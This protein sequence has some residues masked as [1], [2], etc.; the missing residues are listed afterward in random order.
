MRVLAVGG[1]AREHAIVAALA[2]SGADVFACLK[3][4]NPGI[5]KAAKAHILVDESDT[6]KIVE[7][8]KTRDVEL[9]VVGPEAP[10]EV[11]LVDALRSAGVPTA[12]PSKAAAQ[13]ETSKSF[14]RKLLSEHKVKGSIQ[15]AIVDNTRDLKLALDRMGMNV[16]VKPT[17][18]TGG[19]GVKVVGEH[20]MTK[21]DVIA[22]ADEIFTK[23]IGGSSQIVLEEK[24]VGEELTIQAFCDGRRVVPMPAVQDHKR[25]YEGD[26]GPNTGG[27]GSYS[28]N[29]GLLPFLTRKEYDSAV[30]IME[31]VVNALR[32][33]GAEYHGALYGQFMLT[34]DGPKVIE[35][36]ARFGDPEAMNVLSLLS[37]DFTQICFKMA[38]GGISRSHAEFQKKASVCKYVVPEGYG[39]KSLAG[40][41]IKVDENAIANEGALLYYASVNEKDGKIFTTTSRSVGVVGIADSIEQADQIAEKALGHIS[42]RIHVRHDIAKKA[43][44]DAKVARMQNIRSGRV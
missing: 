33:E 9:A 10:L 25:A 16:V 28:Q 44:L 13:I 3:N 21:Q 12:S 39:T 32:K 35:F 30:E 41:E 8:A 6:R 38:E 15:F 18:L 37:S 4:N 34:K 43:M 5:A 2:R 36:N 1:G 11:G 7:F 26:K 17:G 22:Y 19:K 14:M 20:L 31:Q 27:M 42:G 23:R 29:D 24:L 40:E